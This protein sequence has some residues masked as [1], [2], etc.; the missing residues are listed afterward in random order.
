MV[1]RPFPYYQ[2]GRKALAKRFSILLTEIANVRKKD[3]A[4]AIHD[5]RVAS[6]RF[7]AAAQIFSDCC[8][9]LILAECERYVRKLR[10][11]A[12][13]IRDSDVQRL[14]VERLLKKS[15]PRRYLPGLQRLLLRLAQRRE[16]RYKKI[17]SA[18]NTFE[19]SGVIEKMK[20][21]LSLPLPTRRSTVTLRQHAAEAIASHLATFLSYEQYVHQS[22]ALD[23][24]HQMR[25]A[26]KR[27]RYV[28]EIFNPA[29]NGALTPYLRI[30]RSI[31]DTLG[32]MRDC[33]VW[34]LSVPVFL[35]KERKRTEKFLGD[36]SSFRQ[37]EKGILYFAD[38][39]RQEQTKQ[40]KTFVR[41]WNRTEQTQ[42][43]K[44]LNELVMK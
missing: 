30:V 27:L 41:I 38:I 35:D 34:L 4:E 12:G 8:S 43:W 29:Y 32:E 42:T 15:T 33:A 25:I 13:A 5:M 22:S 2:F 39:A 11:S 31:Q 23:E 1:T 28:M 17:L 14:F 36:A 3:D 21:A 6:R 16:K 24:L 44:T 26:A 19:K 7:H 10:K 37:I 20:R 9:G 18:I 40:Y